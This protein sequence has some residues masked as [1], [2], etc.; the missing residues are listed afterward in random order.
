MTKVGEVLF[1]Y[2]L[3][4]IPLAQ[5]HTGTVVALNYLVELELAARGI[6]FVPLRSMAQLPEG[7]HEV[8]QE[9]RDLA[10]QWYRAPEMSFFEHRGILL[11]EQHEVMLSYYL[12]ALRW[13]LSVYEQVLKALA[14]HTVRIPA[15]TRHVPDTAEVTALHKERLP[16]G[17]LELVAA[18][19][20][21]KVEVL[22]PPAGAQVEGRLRR[23]RERGA[24]VWARVA[25]R[26]LNAVVAHTR[27]PHKL[28][29]LA[30]DPWARIAPVLAH[31]PEAEVVLARRS[32]VWAMG[33]GEVWRRRA[34]FYHRLDFADKV[35]RDSARAQ[36]ARFAAQW[37][38]V[39]AALRARFV[40]GGVNVWPVVEP[41]VREL[42]LQD[43]AEAVSIIESYRN[44]LERLEIDCVMLFGSTKGPDNLLARVAESLGVPSIELQHAIETTEP[45]YWAHS[46]LPARYLAAYGALT[47]AHYRTFGVE[48]W[49]VVECGSPRLEHYRAPNNNAAKGEASGMSVLMCGP[50][51]YLALEHPTHSSYAA[52]DTLADMAWAGQQVGVQVLL[53]PRPGMVGN[54]LYYRT[55]IQ[56]LFGDNMRLVHREPLPGLFAVAQVVVAGSSTVALE[57]M[58]ARKPV[59]LYV[60][61][62]ADHDYDEFVA[63]GAVYQARTREALAAALRDLQ[64]AHERAA[65]VERAETFLAAQFAPLLDARASERV[66]ALL[67]RAAHERSAATSKLCVAIDLTE[68]VVFNKE[69]RY[70]A[71]AAERQGASVREIPFEEFKEFYA[72]IVAVKKSEEEWRQ[73]AQGRIAFGAF[74][75]D[76][77]VSAAAIE[78]AGTEAYYS[79]AVT[80]YSLTAAQHA[81]YLLQTHIARALKERG[82]T[83]YVLGTQDTYADKEKSKRIWDFKKQFGQ[84]CRVEGGQ[85][86]FA[87]Y[88]KEGL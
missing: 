22:P 12:Q 66:A 88:S 43:S 59:V 31:V 61:N 35:A 6:P 87:S 69:V 37:P 3:A 16:V 32:Q 68:E 14:P 84:L 34:R 39:L 21:S 73:L 76:E 20:G 45:S 9:A 18:Q 60:P 72:S 86:P 5:R 40:L 23:M 75:G 24:Q 26:V 81:S 44:L 11:G 58:L 55:E 56:K 36:T 13:Y 7:Q 38:Q 33:V 62:P 41:L 77:L 63:A 28:R 10:H 46:R 71:R 80:N 82:F 50:H 53:R 30:T 78:C 51:E 49:R 17:V 8:L 57:A 54:E 52:A 19:R 15:L 70:E 79:M 85:F 25:T 67:R 27:K 47:K 64:D 83:R 4:H 65:Q 1:V 2:E 74:V 48:E 42:V 29:I